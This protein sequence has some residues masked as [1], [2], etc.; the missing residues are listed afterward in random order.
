MIPPDGQLGE[1]DADDP[2]EWQWELAHF[3]DDAHEQTAA[4][5]LRRHCIDKI[6][7]RVRLRAA[8]CLGAH[9]ARRSKGDSPGAIGSVALGREAAG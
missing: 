9:Q 7:V 3:E 1:C 2:S 8:V 5:G 4:A 6:P